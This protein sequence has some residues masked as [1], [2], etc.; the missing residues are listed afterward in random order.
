MIL[1]RFNIFLRLA[2]FILCPSTLVVSS[3]PDYLTSDSVFYESSFV[4]FSFWVIRFL[5]VFCFCIWLQ[6]NGHIVP[7]FLRSHVDMCGTKFHLPHVGDIN[8]LYY[9][10]FN[11]Y[12]RLDIVILKLKMSNRCWNRINKVSTKMALEKV[13]FFNISLYKKDVVLY[14]TGR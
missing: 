6:Y 7:C 4:F 3:R 11:W 12:S 5:T 9:Q 13:A 1:V 14:A 8:L 2:Y 10:Q